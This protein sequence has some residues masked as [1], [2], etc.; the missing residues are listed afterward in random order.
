MPHT[1]PRTPAKCVTFFPSGLPA[2]FPVHDEFVVARDG[3]RALCVPL[4]SAA[5][6]STFARERLEQCLLHVDLLPELDDS[7]VALRLL[8]SCIAQ[9]PSYLLRCV[10]PSRSLTKALPPFDALLHVVLSDI[11]GPSVL[12][13]PVR[14]CARR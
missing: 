12:D 2:C 7:Q 6:V 9:R 14:A 5:F 1:P 10:P 4:G 3:I 13:M 11:I 8:T